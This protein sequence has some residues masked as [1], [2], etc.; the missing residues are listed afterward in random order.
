MNFAGEALGM[1]TMGFAGPGQTLGLGVA[2]L[3]VGA[4]LGAAVGGGIAHSRIKNWKPPSAEESAQMRRGS[5][6]IKDGEKTFYVGHSLKAGVDLK[7]YAKAQELPEGE[8]EPEV[9]RRGWALRTGAGFAASAVPVFGWMAAAGVGSALGSRVLS[10]ETTGELV[11]GAFGALA[12]ATVLSAGQTFGPAG[13]F[14]TALGVGVLG[15]AGGALLAD[16]ADENRKTLPPK[17]METQW[18]S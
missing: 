17:E 3:A 12:S 8:K 2:A 5:L 11:G 18:W 14:G 9:G 13:Y 7:A 16:R 1:L 6:Q 10:D 15:A 4:G